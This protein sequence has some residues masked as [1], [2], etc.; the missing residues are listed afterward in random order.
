[1][2]SCALTDNQNS[3]TSATIYT[4]PAMSLGAE[5]SDRHILILVNAGLT[6]SSVPPISSITVGGNTATSVKEITHTNLGFSIRSAVWIVA[7]PTGTTGAVVITFASSMGRCAAALLRV[8]GLASAAA[9]ATASD[10][11]NPCTKTI[12]V[13]A[14]GLLVGTSCTALSSGTPVCA[15][16]NLTESYDTPITGSTTGTSGAFD[17]FASAQSALSITANWSGG[18]SVITDMALASFSAAA[19][20]APRLPLLSVG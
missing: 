8:T 17:T 13:P 1:M 9:Y 7:V 11:V 20:A 2:I 16:T 14:G 10:T 15:W 6:S 19:T 18:S 3:N 12:D 5:A 4:F